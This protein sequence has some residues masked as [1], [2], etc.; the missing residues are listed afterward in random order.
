MYVRQLFNITAASFPKALPPLP[1]TDRVR[2]V[3]RA[4]FALSLTSFALGVSIMGWTFASESVARTA[5]GLFFGTATISVLL[6]RSGRRPQHRVREGHLFSPHTPSPYLVRTTVEEHKRSVGEGG[7]V[8]FPDSFNLSGDDFMHRWFATLD[9]KRSSNGVVNMPFIPQDLIGIVFDYVSCQGHELALRCYIGNVFDSNDVWRPRLERMNVTFEGG[10]E[11]ECC[12][13]Y[14]EITGGW[15]FAHTHPS[16]TTLPSNPA[17][18]YIPQASRL[19]RLEH[20]GGGN[21]QISGKTPK[22]FTLPIAPEDLSDYRFLTGGQGNCLLAVRSDGLGTPDPENRPTLL[23]ADNDR[24]W[25]LTN[26]NVSDVV[27][28]PC[29]RYLIIYLQTPSEGDPSYYRHKCIVIGKNISKRGSQ[30]CSKEMSA[31]LLCTR[32]TTMRFLNPSMW[33]I[34]GTLV[35]HPAPLAITGDKKVEFKE[36]PSR[37]YQLEGRSAPLQ[38]RSIYHRTQEVAW[39]DQSAISV[40]GELPEPADGSERQGYHCTFAPFPLG[41]DMRLTRRIHAMA[42][43]GPVLALLHS[44]PEATGSIPLTAD[45]W[46]RHAWNEATHNWTSP[47]LLLARHHILNAQDRV[48]QISMW[49]IGTSL[50]IRDRDHEE[51]HF[52]TWT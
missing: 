28:T 23:F 47:P 10:E 29:G 6:L 15:F 51:L 21:F 24:R 34:D 19:Y 5:F 39:H 40:I 52:I 35:I 43:Q 42:T 20:K 37:T 4:F 49:L 3:A 32:R 27:V 12:R 46:Y 1:N 36:A 8:I 11:G 50:V 16:V 14:I 44:H 31:A 22:R 41:G 33:T 13:R 26:P 17:V 2:T 9:Q 48:P 25:K 18:C 7:G 38:C 30:G 45:F